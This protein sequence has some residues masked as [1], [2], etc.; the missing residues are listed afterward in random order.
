MAVTASP[1]MRSWRRSGRR[2]RRTASPPPVRTAEHAG[3]AK[4]WGQRPGSAVDPAYAA[5]HETEEIPDKSDACMT[6]GMPPIEKVVYVTQ[7]ELNGALSRRDIS[8]FADEWWCPGA[9][10]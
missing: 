10:G 2:A 4:L 1:E 8:Q 6:V 9:G 5:V 7:D 3:P